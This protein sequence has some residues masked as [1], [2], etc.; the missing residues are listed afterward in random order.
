M[1]HR[2]TTI[3]F[4][5]FTTF[6]CCY[7]CKT[8]FQAED[9]SSGKFSFTYI[10]GKNSKEELILKE[11]STFTLTSYTYFPTPTCNGKWSIINNDTLFIQ[12]GKEKDPFAPLAR[13]YMGLRERKI[14]IINSNKLKMPIENNVKRKYVI[15]ERVEIN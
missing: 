8:K 13:G 4:L 5:I 9:F 12:C 6:M 2:F 7:S 11:D 15:L 1:K 10:K 3:I 14:K